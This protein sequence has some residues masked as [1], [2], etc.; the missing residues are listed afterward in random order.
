MD[1][2]GAQ[3]SSSSSSSSSSFGLRVCVQGVCG[4]PVLLLTPE[5]PRA[6]CAPDYP[7]VF[8]SEPR[9]PEPV[10][11]MSGSASSARAPYSS[12][13]TSRTPP[14]LNHQRD[15]GILLPL[16]PCGPGWSSTPSSPLMVKRAQILLPGAPHPDLRVENLPF[17]PSHIICR[18][19]AGGPQRR[20]R[21]LEPRAAEVTGVR[22]APLRSEVKEEVTGVRPTTLRSE[23]KDEVTGVRRASLKSEVKDEVTGVRPTTLRS[24]VKGE[25][26]SDPARDTQATPDLLQGQVSGQLDEDSAEPLIR[27]LRAGS[28]ESEAVIRRRVELLM[29]Q[30]DMVKLSTLEECA[31][32]LVQLKALQDSRAALEV[33]V[34]HLQQQ[35]EAEVKSPPVSV[36]L[37]LKRIYTPQIS[38]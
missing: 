19:A 23:V 32:P 7:H 29:E 8:L 5:G 30:M 22:P 14:L 27:L 15:P 20:A 11:S 28:S 10:S 35:L 4:G 38:D 9:R 26:Q 16:D 18:P 24:E 31:G 34:L 2:C 3:D 6:P 1:A 36:A 17:R 13:R 37:L 33:Q 25:E 12:L 21:S